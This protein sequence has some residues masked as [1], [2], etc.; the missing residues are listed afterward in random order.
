VT[1]QSG[2]ALDLLQSYQLA[3]QN[4]PN[5]QAALAETLASREAIPQARSQLL[6]IIQGSGTVSTATTERTSPNFLG[7]ETT[8]KFDYISKNYSLTLRQPLFR[9]QNWAAY[10][11][12]KEQVA[13]AEASLQHELQTLGDKVATAYF[14]ALLA[15][16]HLASV[17][18]QK[19]AYQGQLNAATRN[20]DA[21][22]GTRTDMTEAQARYDFATAQELQAKQ[23]IEY[24]R[25]QLEVLI[26]QRLTED[27][28]KLSPE[29]MELNPIQ[30]PQL[31][32]WIN[33]AEENSPQLNSLKHQ[34]ESVREEVSKAWAGHYPTIDAFAQVSK[35]DSDTN[36]T[37]NQKYDTAQVGVQMVVPIFSGGYV[38]SRVRQAV[39]TVQQA[40]K[41]VEARRLALQLDVRKQFQNIVE[42]AA[43]IRALENAFRSAEL[44]LLSNQKGFQ[45]G[46]RAS[47]DVLNAIMQ[48]AMVE[49]D[50]AQARYEYS[51]ARIRLMSLVGDLDLNLITTVNQWLT[52]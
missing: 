40:E 1:S 7:R 16:D 49:N 14:N 36:V 20:F 11:Q 41:Q 38:N 35:A 51:L 21:G 22:F 31:E 29:R 9:M 19:E 13:G 42:G 43:K 8:S 44:S 50:L 2:F 45:A 33:K 39:A 52:M 4:E 18:A 32:K 47:I 17:L 25:Q 34:L 37:I 6:P 27:L 23:D 12:A 48:K 3:L 46:I 10:R 26:N 28:A 24:T 5:Y 30:P 15:K